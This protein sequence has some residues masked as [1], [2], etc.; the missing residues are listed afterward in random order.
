MITTIIFWDK[1]FK[2]PSNNGTN[3]LLRM[4]WGKRTKVKEKIIWMI[5]SMIVGKNRHKGKVTIEMIRYSTKYMDWDNCMSMAKIPMDAM[6][7]CKLIVDDSP[8]Y[9]I[10]LIPK[11]VKHSNNIDNRVE[12]II[13]DFLT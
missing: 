5:K 1:E 7:L 13:K 12:F 8:E 2:L 6:K 10:S 4:H 3:G 11:Q 9:V